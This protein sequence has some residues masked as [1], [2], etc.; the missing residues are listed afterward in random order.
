MTVSAMLR[1][2]TY[3]STKGTKKRSGHYPERTEG[4]ATDS[5]MNL[6]ELL[7]R[8]GCNLVAW[9]VV[10]THCLWLATLRI[11]GSE[12]LSDE[13]WR[14]LLGFAPVAIGFSFLL[15]AM[16]KMPEIARILRVLGIPMAVLLPLAAWPVISALKTSTFGSSPLWGIEIVGWHA[17][18]A[19]VQLISLVV[20]AFAIIRVWVTAGES[21]G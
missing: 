20:I 7:L 2:Q 12:A 11:T 6:I 15:S 14:L 17:W 21:S 16:N 8:L 13:F 3:I 1:R 9:I 4:R 10:Y 18:W 5:P 19:P